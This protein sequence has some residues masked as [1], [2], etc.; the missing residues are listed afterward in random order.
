MMKF[1]LADRLHI[2]IAEIER[3]PVELFLEWLAFFRVQNDKS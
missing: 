3:M 2:S 1:A